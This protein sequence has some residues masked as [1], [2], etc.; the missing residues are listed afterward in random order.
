MRLNEERVNDLNGEYQK[1]IQRFC[2]TQYYFFQRIYG[3][4]LVWSLL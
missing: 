3:L 4:F 1:A 2:F